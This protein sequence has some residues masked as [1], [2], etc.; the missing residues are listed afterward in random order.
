MP[1]SWTKELEMGIPELDDLQKALFD[2]YESFSEHG[3]EFYSH[4]VFVDLFDFMDRYIHYY[5]K[6]EELLLE[7]SFFPSREEHVAAHQQFVAEIE[8]FK[9]RLGSGEETKGMAIELKRLMIRWLVMHSK[10]MDKD[11]LDYLLESVERHHSELAGKKLGEIL[12]K[13]GLITVEMLDAA[14]EEQHN[15]NKAL[16]IV[17]VEMGQIN[18]EQIIEALAIQKGML[19]V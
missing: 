1:L 17:L 19:A 11:F 15:S 13:T 3:D 10:H 14:L 6:Y 12:L 16:G 4:E 5:L 2:K 8:G 7:K 9:N 18:T